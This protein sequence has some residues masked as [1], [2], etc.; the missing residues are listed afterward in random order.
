MLRTPPDLPRR[1]LEQF[2]RELNEK[3]FGL[4]DS[5]CVRAYHPST[6][7]E[8]D[9]GTLEHFHIFNND[10]QAERVR[11]KPVV[12][13]GGLRGYWCLS[14]SGNGS[15]AF[16]WQLTEGK[17]FP[18]PGGNRPIGGGIGFELKP[19]QDVFSQTD[20]CVNQ[21][22]GNWD[23]VRVVDAFCGA[24]NM[25][26]MQ[27]QTT[28][29]RAEGFVKHHHDALPIHVFM[30]RY[31]PFYTL[32]ERK[33]RQWK[34]SIPFY[35]TDHYDSITARQTAPSTLVMPWAFG[36]ATL[37]KVV[38]QWR[39]VHLAAEAKKYRPGGVGH[40]RARDNFERLAGGPSSS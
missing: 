35:F 28:I 4:V 18:G 12:I 29:V 6:P 32:R 40:K 16:R 19:G 14:G 10:G 20:L 8:V 21:H 9:D 31:N 3:P 30:E 34:T 11:M 1:N 37:W 36:P 7:H 25:D 17:T 15:C 38:K 26:K 24:A 33:L 5:V 23:S 2:R 39:K 27:M 22:T 13:K